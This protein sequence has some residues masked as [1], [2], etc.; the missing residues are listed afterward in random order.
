MRGLLRE[1]GGSGVS[2]HVQADAGFGDVDGDEA[3]EER[4]GGEDFEVDEGFQAEAADG[5]GFGVAGDAGDEGP[6]DEGVMMTRM[7]RR[8]MSPKTRLERAMCGASRRARCRPA[9]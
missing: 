2:A 6:E 4:D 5:F 9:C 1:R 8:K 7:R 3:D